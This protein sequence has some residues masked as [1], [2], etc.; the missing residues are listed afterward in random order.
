ML[1]FGIR[2][3]T[4][5]S[6][7]PQTLYLSYPALSFT[8]RCRRELGYVVGALRPGHSDITTFYTPSP[9][10]WTRDDTEPRDP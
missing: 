2:N 10:V 3:A 1:A 5:V 9:E 8:A 4:I 6:Q 7:A